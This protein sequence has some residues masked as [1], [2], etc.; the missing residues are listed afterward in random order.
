MTGQHV[1]RKPLAAVEAAERVLESLGLT[2][3]PVTPAK[4]LDGLG[5][6]TRPLP[7]FDL[8]RL[9][10]HQRRTLGSVRGILSPSDRM[11]YVREGLSVH[12]VP[13]LVYHESGHAEIAWHRELLYL[14][15]DYT[16]GPQVREIMERE[17][18]E[19]AAHLQ[20]LGPLFSVEAQLIPFGAA[21]V[22]ELADRYHASIESTMRRYVE[23]CP[24][25][26][27]C[28]VLQPAWTPEGE[29]TLRSRY[30]VKSKLQPA[31]WTFG[32]K[33]G[34]LLAPDDPLVRFFVEGPLDGRDSSQYN[35][36]HPDT[37][38]FLPHHVFSNGHSV[39]VLASQL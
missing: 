21:A 32:H 26:C 7:G 15:N 24:Q 36:R 13:W 22:L 27:V 33:I 38:A 34:E 11:I 35:V 6:I 19:F 14:D 17:A 3:P 31:Y 10:A 29:P 28:L 23:T 8:D 16:L 1:T 4:I 2:E 30:F 18:N 39:F 12:Q 5:L 9:S 20:F 37:G 25:S